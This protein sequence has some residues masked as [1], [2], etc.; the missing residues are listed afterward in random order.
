MGY[1]RPKAYITCQGPKFYTI[2]DFWRLIWQEEIETI[3]MATNFFEDTKRMCAEYWPQKLNTLFECGEMIIKLIKQENYE[4]H[5]FR[6]FEIYYIQHCRKIKHL[7]LRWDSDTTLYPNVVVPVVKYIRQIT[8]NSVVPIL[9][10]SGFGVNRTGTL[11]LCDL[12]LAMANAENEV[13]FFALMKNLREQKPYMVNKMEL[14]LLIHLIILECFMELETPFKKSLSENFD[15]N[16]IKQQLSYLKRFNWYDE[17]V[18]SWNPEPPTSDNKLPSPT[19]VDGYK[20]NKK[21]LIMQQPQKKMASKFW[22]VVAANKISHILFL[23][24]LRE[25]QFLWP[26]RWNTHS[27]VIT[28]RYLAGEKTGYVT[29]TQLE[30]QVYEKNDGAILYENFVEVFEFTDWNEKQQFPNSNNNFF[31]IIKQFNSAKNWA[32]LVACSDGL[33]ACGLFVVLSYILEKYENELEIDVC[34]A[35]RIARRSG[36]QFVN[37]SKQLSFIYSFVQ[38]YFRNF[39]AYD[40]IEE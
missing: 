3:V 22:T 1:D 7:H 20:R 25:K 30:L 11:I 26:Q 38:H 27:K 12:A 5:D 28:V 17:I 21:Y 18:K 39:E 32:P 14:Y 8:E 40:H 6:I 19:Y 10:H 37:N 24:K 31:Q 29:K 36:K 35:I 33:G 2:K 9:I 34:N 16:V 15:T 23:N 13:N 4:Y